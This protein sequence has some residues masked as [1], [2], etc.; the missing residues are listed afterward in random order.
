MARLRVRPDTPAVTA[1]QAGQWLEVRCRRCRRQALLPPG[2]Y[3]EAG[4]RPLSRLAPIL[5]C[6][7]CG[8]RGQVRVWLA[9]RD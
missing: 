9:G 5:R 1:A 3:G 2:V 7:A 4:E 6:T 8:T